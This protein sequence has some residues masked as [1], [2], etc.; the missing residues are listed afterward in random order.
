MKLLVNASSLTPPIT[1]IGRYTYNLMYE[2]EQILD[3]EFNYLYDTAW[4][5]RLVAIK[6][7]TYP[8]V[9]FKNL[10][11]KIVPNAYGVAKWI[12][13]RSFDS[14]A[15]ACAVHSTLYHE[16]NYLPLQ[17]AGKTVVTI[18]DLSVLKHP[19][20]HPADRVR[21]FH[22]SLPK[23][24]ECADAIIVDSEFIKNEVISQFSVSPEKVFTTLLGV[25]D[26]FRPYK[27]AAVAGVLE[28]HN[29]AY[30][31]YILVVGTLEP[32]KNLPLILD[33]YQQLASEIRKRY[34]LVIAGMRGWNLEQFNSRLQ[35]MVHDG[36][37]RLLGYV[38]DDE[39]PMVY[40]GA[41]VFLFPSK[42][43]GFG[44]PPLE[45]MASGVPVIASRRASI[46]EVVG[47][48]GILLEAD[49][50]EAWT[51]AIADLLGNV[52]QRQ[53]MADAGLKRAEEFTWRRCAE[54]TIRAYEYA[55]GFPLPRKAAITD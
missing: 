50:P 29:L 54:Q 19:E 46:P 28:K 1:G 35:Q 51:S 40:A 53:G 11:K 3:I 5:S 6:C 14:C 10:F 23:V 7:T 12:R 20:S 24:A 16:P 37:V 49:E 44:L 30:K 9:K 34:P 48:A 45:A 43:E 15:H 17:F 33:S 31:E 8:A 13:Q 41:S 18:H 47:D 27:K 21:L 39:L 52:E 26:E 55:L 25:G 4:S 32:R 38:A 22:E 2:L 36:Q 42:Y